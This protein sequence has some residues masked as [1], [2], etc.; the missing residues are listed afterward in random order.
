MH[1]YDDTRKIMINKI[2]NIIHS[3]Y[4][5]KTYT[6]LNTFRSIDTYHDQSS[7]FVALKE[8][9]DAHCNTI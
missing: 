7:N 5:I 2:L 1:D 9:G 8:T 4:E 6:K 3:L